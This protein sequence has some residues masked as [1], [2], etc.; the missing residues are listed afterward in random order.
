MKEIVKYSI[1]NKLSKTIPNIKKII[2]D[3]N[4]YLTVFEPK[5]HIRVHPKTNAIPL[6]DQTVSLQ[7]MD[8]KCYFKDRTVYFDLTYFQPKNKTEKEL[9]SYF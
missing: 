5:L 9:L 6:N 3:K 4:N 1:E 7:I 8:Y 2:K